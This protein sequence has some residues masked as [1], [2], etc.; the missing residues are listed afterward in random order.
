MD[1]HLE[2]LYPVYVFA[3]IFLFASRPLSDPDFWW[4]LKAGEHIVKTGV[5][6]R[7]DFFSFTNYGRE[8]VAH[9]WLSEA[10]FYAVYSRLGFGALIFLCAAVTACAFWLVY[11]L[12]PAHPILKGTAVLLGAWA[13]L[14][15]AGVRPRTFTLLL[16][17]FYLYILAREARRGGAGTALWWLAPLMAVWVNLHGGFILGFALIALAAAGALLDGWAAGE[18]LRATTPR[19]KRLGLVLAGCFC[20]A[21]LNPTGARIF[22][23]PFEIFLSPVQQQEIVDWLS[24]NFHQSETAP[25]AALILLTTAA[26]ALSPVRPRPGQ[27]LL[28]LATLYATLK[29]NRHVAIF[30]LVAPPLLAAHAQSWLGVTPLRRLFAPDDAVRKEV[31]SP[32]VVAVMLLPL[33]VFV[34]RLKETAYAPPRQEMVGVPIK[35]VAFMKREGLTG[36]TFTDVN[37]WGGYLIWEA[38]SNPVYVD[39][40]VDMYGDEFMREYVDLIR[41]LADWRAPFERHGVRHAV[42]ETK[43]VLARE[44]AESPD[45]REVYADEKARV[46]TKLR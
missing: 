29:S 21:L 33:L 13:I 45:W 40:R 44:I 1:K 43:S 37:V 39:G 16:A 28:L 12:T 14:P 15:V 22:A 19:L 35:A 4:H 18:P 24:P 9:E 32:L 11:K 42:V 38:P 26:L 2:R 8:W 5:I 7:T 17:S 10:L 31:L 34:P 27:L 3:L 41:G 46:F 25:L 36:N 20:A 23:F 6:P 30:A